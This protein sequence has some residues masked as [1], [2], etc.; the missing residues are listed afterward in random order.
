M[1]DV[2]MTKEE[3]EEF[4]AKPFVGIISITHPDAGR[5]PVASPIWYDF[6]PEAGVWVL[7][8]PT[9]IKGKALHQ[10]KA[11]A[12]AVQEDFLPYR[13]VTASGPV[14]EVREAERERD[15]R[16]M[17]HRYLGEEEGDRYT[18]TYPDGAFGHVYRMEPRY[19]LTNDNNKNPNLKPA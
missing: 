19:W 4:L 7:T 14:V 3:R 12:M 8:G 11:F 2:R 15:L 5:A 13:Y 17:A 10:A 16:P 18:A 6:T 1:I 9:S